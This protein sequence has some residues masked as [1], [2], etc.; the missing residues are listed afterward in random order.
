MP[1]FDL[2]DL[3]ENIKLIREKLAAIES[4]D[5][6]ANIKPFPQENTNDSKIF[7]ERL[8]FS[9]QNQES[10]QITFFTV[11]FITFYSSL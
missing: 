3:S 4:S 6:S 2:K 8:E 7:H 5:F 10:S 11:F 1:A 9:L